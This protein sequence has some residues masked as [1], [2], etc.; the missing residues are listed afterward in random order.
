MNG[1]RTAT[2]RRVKYAK[3]YVALGLLNEASDELEAIDFGDRFLPEVVST[4]IDLH[5]ER[6]Q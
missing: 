4:R 3:G 5:M 6:E 1:A 2:C